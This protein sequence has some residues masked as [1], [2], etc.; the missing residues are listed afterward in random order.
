MPAEKAGDGEQ[1]AELGCGREPVAFAGEELGLVGN[2]E[3]IEKGGELVGLVDRNDGVGHAVKDEGGRKAGGG[4]G[5]EVLGHAAGDL[6]DGADAV[7]DRGAGEGEEGAER[8]A[9][10][11]DAV[12]VDGGV[13]GDVG[14]GVANGLEPLREVDAVENGG[15][16]G[17]DGSGAVEVVDG[18]ETDAEFFEMRGE[19][20]KP[21]ADVSA[22]AVH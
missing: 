2:M 21:E 20:V 1:D 9:D 15:G 6:D 4:G 11:G 16:V 22:G 13:G 17:V 8:D 3:A 18:E 19:A 5:G 10:E 14:E 12:G 7:I